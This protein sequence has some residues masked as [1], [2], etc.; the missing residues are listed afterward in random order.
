VEAIRDGE[1]DGQLAVDFFSSASG[2]FE[3]SLERGFECRPRPNSS[4][5][6]FPNLKFMSNH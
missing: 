5:P 6:R 4:L 3:S 1:E 2:I